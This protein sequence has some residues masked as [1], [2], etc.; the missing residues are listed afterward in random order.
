VDDDFNRGRWLLV[1]VRLVVVVSLAVL[2]VTAGDD[3]RY[4]WWVVFGVVA[5][6]VVLVWL[7]LRRSL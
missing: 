3:W 6:G 4:G 5:L 7:L 1:G 2:A